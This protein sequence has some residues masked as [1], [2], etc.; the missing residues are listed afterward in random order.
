M[1]YVHQKYFFN[2]CIFFCGLGNLGLQDFLIIE[3]NYNGVLPQSLRDLTVA[4]F[5]V[6]LPCNYKK[7]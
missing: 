3:W 4:P 7:F 6:P 5:F 2:T 1:Y